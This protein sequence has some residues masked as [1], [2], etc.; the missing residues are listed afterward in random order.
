MSEAEVGALVLGT[1]CLLLGPFVWW[2][3]R[4]AANGGLRRNVYAGIRTSRTL[5][6]D[7][8]W[9]E[10]HRA[11]VP[12]TLGAAVVADTA[13]I[14]A[15]ALVLSGRAQAAFVVGL[16]GIVLL[17]GGLLLAVPAAHR[18]IGSGPAGRLE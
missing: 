13:G 15:V 7:E 9:V 3:T 2:L 16:A 1:T 8:A 17:L 18:A 14:A 5:Q 4:L 11:A 6:T 10:G 12:W